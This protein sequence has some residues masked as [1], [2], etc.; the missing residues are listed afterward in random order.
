MVIENSPGSRPEMETL[1][2]LVSPRSA[3]TGNDIAII[4]NGELLSSTSVGHGDDWDRARTGSP[5]GGGNVYPDDA[6]FHHNFRNPRRHRSAVSRN[7]RQLRGM[8][9]NLTTIIIP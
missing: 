3:F 6:P 8:A 5:E 2:R 7:R 1:G 9:M 4:V